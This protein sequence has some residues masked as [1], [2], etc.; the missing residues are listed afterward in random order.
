MTA[1]FS[2]WLDIC[3]VTS[4]HGLR[5]LAPAIH[6]D[7]YTLCRHRSCAVHWHQSVVISVYSQ[8]GQR[9]TA[10]RQVHDAP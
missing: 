6:V 4:K 8:A 5:P 7:R 2:V 9:H 1:G 10:G 3:S